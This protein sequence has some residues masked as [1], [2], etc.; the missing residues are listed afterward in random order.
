M[1]I[2]LLIVVCPVSF[3]CPKSGTAYYDKEGEALRCKTEVGPNLAPIAPKPLLVIRGVQDLKI[4][5][6]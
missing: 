1:L 5:K 4:P 3:G 2:T 6:G